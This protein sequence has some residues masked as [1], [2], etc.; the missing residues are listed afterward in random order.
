MT[1]SDEVLEAA[2][3]RCGMLRVDNISELFDM[4]EVLCKQPRPRGPQSRG[5]HQC[6]RSRRAGNGRPADN[7]GTT[8]R[9][10]C[11]DERGPQKFLPAAW[12]HANPVDTL[13]DAGPEMYAKA[14]QAERTP[15]CDGVLFILA[16][17]GMTERSKPRP[18]RKAAETIK[19][20]LLASWMGG[21]RMQLAANVL[22]EARFPPSNILTRRREVL[23]TCGVIAP[24]C[25]RC[26][27]HQMFAG[28]LPEEGPG[29]WRKSLREPWPR[30]GRS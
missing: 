12:S 19:K 2:F 26:M 21:S 24:T 23:P 9:S 29:A 20:P 15:N 17:Q 18:V 3:H 25:R 4:A 8:G 5:G 14:L 1:G 11:R 30:T 13:G 28:E 10:V 22:N 6:R 16:P 7:R 27:K